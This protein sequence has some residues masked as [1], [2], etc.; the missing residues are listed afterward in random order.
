[1]SSNNMINSRNEII[2]EL[3]EFIVDFFNIK[4]QNKILDISIF[5]I[6]EEIIKNNIASDYVRFIK[7]NLKN[8]KYNYLTNIQ[9]FEIMSED[10]LSSFSQLKVEEMYRCDIFSENL[11]RKIFVF[12]DEVNFELQIRNQVIENLKIDNFFTKIEIEIINRIGGKV[13]VFNLNNLNK[14]LLSELIINKVIEIK[15][16]KNKKEYLLKNNPET[17][18]IER[19]KNGKII[20]N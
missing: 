4:S 11:R 5:Q 2:I 8:I 12:F 6:S 17:N 15:I 9:K 19:L 10:F 16:E 20:K 7:S 18:L 1:M 14:E 13:R 3:C